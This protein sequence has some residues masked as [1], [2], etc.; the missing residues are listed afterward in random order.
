LQ[1][2]RTAGRRPPNPTA[3]ISPPRGVYLDHRRREGT[4]SAAYALGSATVGSSNI[5]FRAR[6]LAERKHR[7]LIRIGSLKR[8]SVFYIVCVP[9]RGWQCVACPLS[10]FPPSAV[11]CSVLA[12]RPST[13]FG[14]AREAG[15]RT[16]DYAGR[17]R[18]DPGI[19]PIGS[20]KTRRS[21][22]RTAMGPETVMTTLDGPLL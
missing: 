20:G 21:G 2:T 12:G 5:Q 11:P 16:I 7:P 22:P 6:G 3:E 10:A 8:V 15:R 18:P 17:P 9:G 19:R 14:G 1:R 4:P 13:P